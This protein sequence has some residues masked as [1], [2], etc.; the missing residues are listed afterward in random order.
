[1]C[2]LIW[3]T[4]VSTDLFSVSPSFAPSGR[5]RIDLVADKHKLAVAILQRIATNQSLLIADIQT[6]TG[7]AGTTQLIG[8]GFV[9]SPHGQGLRLDRTKKAIV[10]NRN[11]AA[12]LAQFIGKD[13]FDYLFPDESWSESLQ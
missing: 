3:E 12:K 13:Q 7:V 9:K 6:E 10:R 11:N 8:L 4:F 1:M 5:G 2:L